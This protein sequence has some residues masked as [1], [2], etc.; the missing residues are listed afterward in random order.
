[1]PNKRLLILTGP[2]G[3]GN[4]LFS[5]VFSQHPEV[6]GW[7]ALKSQ[8]WIPSD[9][10]PF[11]EYWVYP[12]R[13]AAERF[14]QKSY[15]F[16][17]VS[18]PFFYDGVRQIP[19]IHDVAAL[20]QSF[21]VEVVIA[22]VTR[23]VN[24]NCYQ[25]HRVGGQIT[26]EQAMDYYQESLIPNYECHF[27]SNEAFFLWKDH[28]VSY[29]GRLLK[30]PVLPDQHNQLIGPNPNSKYVHTVEEQQL[31]KV[32]REGR[33]KFVERTFNTLKGV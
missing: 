20:A 23:D 28:Y 27:I 19:K 1:M 13:L 22:I 9:Q 26:L 11:A 21:G 17:N 25:Q 18:T 16:A 29:L 3:S 4:H 12:E 7:E 15:Y 6:E 32:I 30:F 2:Q 5:R 8:Y 14:S 33:K 24:I 10:E 31:D